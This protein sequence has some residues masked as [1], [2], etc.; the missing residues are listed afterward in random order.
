MASESIAQEAEGRM[1]YWPNAEWP[2]AEW[3]IDSEP[4]RAR[5]I[6]VNES[7]NRTSIE[8]SQNESNTVAMTNQNKQTARWPN[9]DPN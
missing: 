5:G 9:H 1:G 4:I 2:K 3:A 6:I 7:R 8:F